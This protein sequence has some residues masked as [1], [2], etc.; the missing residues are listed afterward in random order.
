MSFS[1]SA[2]IKEAVAT[3]QGHAMQKRLAAFATR[4]DRGIS[5]IVRCDEATLT[6]ITSSGRESDFPA[7]MPMAI[8]AL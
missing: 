4:Q 6:R 2:G 3:K 8:I 7:D 1:A 5:H